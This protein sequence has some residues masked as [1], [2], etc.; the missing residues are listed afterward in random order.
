M[1]KFELDPF[2]FR[3]G[4]CPEFLCYPPG[5][6]MKC[7][8]LIV[9]RMLRMPSQEVG[10]NW[11]LYQAWAG[12]KIDLLILVVFSDSW[13]YPVTVYSITCSNMLPVNT[14]TVRGLAL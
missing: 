3:F 7:C 10:R 13:M 6:L 12:Q 8:R 1:K 11:L 14:M 4:V 2:Q 9:I 5:L